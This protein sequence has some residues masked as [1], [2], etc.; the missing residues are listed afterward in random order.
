MSGPQPISRR[1]DAL[2]AV[3]DSDARVAALRPHTDFGPDYR[4]RV[5]DELDRARHM[6]EIDAAGACLVTAEIAAGL[7]PKSDYHDRFDP[8]VYG[9]SP[10][11]APS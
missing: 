4:P 9:R 10:V 11:S 6:W 2:R 7:R 8:R 1:G 5:V 3:P